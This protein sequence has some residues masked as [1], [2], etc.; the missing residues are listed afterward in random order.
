[1]AKAAQYEYVNIS[2]H[3]NGPESS[4][5]P[6]IFLTKQSIISRHYLKDPDKRNG[7]DWK[8]HLEAKQHTE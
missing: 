8:H 4:V 3:E 2:P 7:A 6:H 5:R 1:M